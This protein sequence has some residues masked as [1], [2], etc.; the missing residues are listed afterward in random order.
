MIERYDVSMGVDLA[1][2]KGFPE[3]PQCEGRRWVVVGAIEHGD[4]T[5]PLEEPCPGCIPR[6][7]QRDKEINE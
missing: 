7:N 5:L 1:D 4:K 2:V 3:C 6:L